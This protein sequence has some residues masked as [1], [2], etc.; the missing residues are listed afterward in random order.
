M[1]TD[2]LNAAAAAVHADTAETYGVWMRWASE[3]N[4]IPHVTIE[5]VVTAADRVGSGHGRVGS[6]RAG[7]ERLPAVRPSV[8]PS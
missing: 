1:R 6:G 8:R 3:M 5:R 7:P 4:C 2:G